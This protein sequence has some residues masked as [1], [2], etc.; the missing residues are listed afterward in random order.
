[1]YKNYVL[2]REIIKFFSLNLKEKM[3]K[4]GG[5]LSVIANLVWCGGGNGKVNG[6]ETFYSCTDVVSK[7]LSLIKYHHENSQSSLPVINYA[8]F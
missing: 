6:A 4:K 8:S 1:M 3:R 5:R 2:I 7:Y